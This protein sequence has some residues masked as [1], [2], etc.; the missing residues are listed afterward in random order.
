VEQHREW[1]VRSY[2]VTFGFVTFRVV[3]AILDIMEFGTMVERMTAASWLGWIVPLFLTESVMQGRK[4]FSK[5]HAPAKL[6]EAPYS[7][8]PAAEPVFHLHSSDSS[9]P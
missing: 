2:A 3:Y 4:I 5:R 1:M 6:S 8:L 9:V 7:V